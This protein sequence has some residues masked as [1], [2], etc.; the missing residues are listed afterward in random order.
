[1]DYQRIIDRL[2]EQ[3]KITDED[4]KGAEDSFEEDK[5]A[6][7]TLLHS[8]ICAEKHISVEEYAISMP[9]CGFYA[10]EQVG[11]AWSLRHHKTWLEIA[12]EFNYLF[13]EW[14]SEPKTIENVCNALNLLSKIDMQEAISMIQTLIHKRIENVKPLTSDSDSEERKS[15]DT[16]PGFPDI[17]S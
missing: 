1:M 12:I 13:P 5:K 11:D 9:G 8:L 10:E 4:I 15:L 17:G 7:A 14:K 2:K 6:L 16:F 3:G